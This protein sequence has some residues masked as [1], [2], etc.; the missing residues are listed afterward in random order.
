M[1]NMYSEVN[2]IKLAIEGDVGARMRVEVV[3]PWMN[4]LNDSIKKIDSAED[5]RNLLDNSVLCIALI[6]SSLHENMGWKESD[7]F[8]DFAIKA[9]LDKVYDTIKLYEKGKIK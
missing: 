6:V 1:K 8:L 7:P 3:T 2:D 4:L 9:Y 5:A